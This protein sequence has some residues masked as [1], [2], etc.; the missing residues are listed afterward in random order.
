[1]DSIDIELSYD[2]SCAPA[3]TRHRRGIKKFGENQKQPNYSSKSSQK[4]NPTDATSNT[5]RQQPETSN[6]QQPNN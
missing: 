3:D 5:Q 2:K 4:R 1:M 6:K